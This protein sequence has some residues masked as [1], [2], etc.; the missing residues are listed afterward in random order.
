[1]AKKKITIKD[2][3]DLMA[4]NHE[5]VCMFTAYGVYYG[6]TQRDGMKTVEDCKKSMNINCK[7]AM[8]TDIHHDKTA[9]V[10][11]ICGEIVH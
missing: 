1:M 3:L 6:D 11:V 10:I 2:V 8:V 7:T 5:V 4:D 9:N